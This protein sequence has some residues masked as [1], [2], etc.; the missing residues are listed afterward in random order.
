[1]SNRK[2]ATIKLQGM[3]TGIEKRRFE[4]WCKKGKADIFKWIKQYFDCPGKFWRLGHTAS[5]MIV[6]TVFTS[7]FPDWAETKE[8]PIIFVANIGFIFNFSTTWISTWIWLNPLLSTVEKYMLKHTYDV[9]CGKTVSVMS[10]FNKTLPS[11]SSQRVYYC[12]S[13]LKTATMTHRQYRFIWGYL[14]SPYWTWT[15]SKLARCSAP[16]YKWQRSLL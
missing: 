5:G 3:N 11:S 16:K 13:M 14:P 2:Y 15:F 12:M 8:D 9:D 6:I 10:S 7:S 1:M 4:Y